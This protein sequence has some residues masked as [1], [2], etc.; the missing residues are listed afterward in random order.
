MRAEGISFRHAVELLR[1]DV[2]AISPASSSK[3]TA[4]RCTVAKLE[5]FIDSDVNTNEQLHQVMD[6]YHETLKSSPEALAYLEKRGL[7]SS[8]VVKRFRLGFANRT[9]GYHL[10]QKTG[11]LVRRFVAG[12]RRSESFVRAVMSISAG[13]W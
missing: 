4:K 10:P 1:K 7:S 2:T 6:Y 5:T 13:H 9:I 11:K 12:W 8:E 3:K